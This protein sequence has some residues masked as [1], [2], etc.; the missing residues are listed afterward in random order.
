[1]KWLIGIPVTYA[2]MW[3]LA[4]MS[5]MGADFSYADR[6]FRWGFSGGEIPVFINMT[7][8]LVTL[9]VWGI[10]GLVTILRQSSK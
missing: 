4:Y 6:Y 9:L 8:I 5:V 3:L 7:A 10:I 2:A 1:M